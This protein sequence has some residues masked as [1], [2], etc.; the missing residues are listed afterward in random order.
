LT[1]TGKAIA[2]V[3]ARMSSSR[4]PG[5]VMMDLG[6]GPMILFMMQRLVRAKQLD[7][8]C[9]ATSEEASDD[10]LAKAAE[11]A[12]I[13][14]YRGSLN[15]VLGRYIGAARAMD[16]EIV[17]RLT[18][19]CPLI[20]ADIIDRSISAVRGGNVTYVSN[21]NPPSY[22]DGL[23]VE[24]MT[25]AALETANT[26]A[27]ATHQREHVTP[28]IRENPE[29]FPQSS[30][31]SH[32]DLSSLRWTVD[33]PEDLEMVRK[34]VLAMGARALTADRFDFLRYIEQTGLKDTADK[35][36]RNENYRTDAS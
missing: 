23:D 25:M 9:I 34:L 29:R 28:F 12:N 27:S 8:F 16:A 22:P 15:D 20:D 14:V 31:T 18:G 4:L 6:G 19:D 24:A 35:F 10:P 32:I 17:V 30:L 36:N 21:T 33:H 7:G 5:K 1:A 11:E 3:Q 2:I 13:T 26:E